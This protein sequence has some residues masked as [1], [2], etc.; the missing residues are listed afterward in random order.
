VKVSR[1]P[2]SFWDVVDGR[3]VV[4]DAGSGELLNLNETAALLWDACSDA[5]L[6]QLVEL[7]ARA[8]PDQDIAG[9]AAD[10]DQFVDAMRGHGLLAT[11]DCSRCSEEG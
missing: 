3:V 7:L 4:C 1:V 6:R 9:L 10:V 2:T 11:H 8:F 5:S